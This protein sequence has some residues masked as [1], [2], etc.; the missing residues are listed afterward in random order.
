LL[1]TCSHHGFETW[2]LVS[3]FYEGL[4]PKDRQ[5]VELMCNETFENKDPDE[6]M[7]YLDLLAENAQNW[8]TTGTYEAP[9]K[10]QPHTSSGGM[11]NLREDHDLQAKFASLARKVE[12][13]ECKKSGQL[14]SVQDIVCQICETNE[15]ATNDCPTLSSFKE[16]LH[17]QVR[18]LNSFK[19]QI[20]THTLKYKDPGCLTISC[21]IGEHK[22]ER[23]LLDLGASVN[24][25]PYSFFQSLNLGELK[26]TSVTLL[27]AD[28][29]VKV[30]RGIVED[31]LVQVDKFIYPVDFVVLDTQLVEA[32][33][34]FLSF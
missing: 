31:V 11:Y 23:A 10:T 4:T 22:I 34:K 29:S 28:R 14:K 17:E 30:P 5:M 18:A 33:N 3:Q 13:L 19:G 20:I 6:A 21:F 15:H 26:P 8:D 16:C 32:C 1:N 7:E 27:F 2:R 25:L 12:A 24:L 9:G